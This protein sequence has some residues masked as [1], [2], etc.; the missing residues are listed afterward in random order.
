MKTTVIPP[1]VENWYSIR[2][3][4]ISLHSKIVSGVLNKRP[5]NR[6]TILLKYYIDVSSEFPI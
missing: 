6:A 3:F 4:A 2:P 1:S 5:E